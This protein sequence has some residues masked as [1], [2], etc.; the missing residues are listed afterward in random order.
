M[1][2]L[3]VEDDDSFARVLTATLRRTGF[4]V[5]HVRTGQEA[6]AAPVC[7]VAL[8]DLN[9]PDTDGLALCGP[10]RAAGHAA[11]IVV[12]ARTE[13]AH[14][15]MA[16]RAG[17]DDYLVKPFGS[18][19]L[20]ARVEAVLRR[21]RPRSL[22]VRMIGRLRVDLDRHEV[23]L[24]GAPVPLNRKE[25][26]LL[27]ALA[28]EPDR[29]HERDK[30]LQEVWDTDWA[31]MTRTFEVHLA[32]LRAKIASAAVVENVRG[33]GYRLREVP[34]AAAPSKTEAS[35]SKTEAS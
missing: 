16:L 14:R 35:P 27:A 28:R 32:R 2:V 7:D 1:K 25:F 30:L 11:I 6:I 34:D 29:P 12:S 22:G 3:L 10:L 21:A 17:A 15:V 20:Q 13:E 23:T 33:V 5:H 31:G 26:Q 19:E 18:E 9:L 8:L 4:V 24:D